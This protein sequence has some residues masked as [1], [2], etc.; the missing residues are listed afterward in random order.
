MIKLPSENISFW[1]ASYPES[2]YPKLTDGIEVDVVVVGAGITGLTTAYLLK[3]AG[4]TVVVLDKATIGGGTTGRTT[5]K[6]TSQHNL[7][8]TDL[9]KRLGT[10]KAKLYGQANQVAVE[11]VE[12]II[13]QEKIDCDWQSQDNFVFTTDPAKVGDYKVEAGTAA[14]L[15]LSATFE[16]DI[17][18]PF[19]VKGA[20]KF[21]GQAKMN[22]QKYLIGLAR[23]VD[24]G[25]S[26]VFEN[27]NVTRI[28]GG[29]N[30][31]VKANGATVRSKH[32]VV[33][34]NV[35]TLPLLAR[36][37]YCL[38]EYP[39]ESYIVVG[40][41]DKKY[42]GMYIS[43]DKNNYSVLPM[44]QGDKK[45]ILIGG[46]GHFSGM[47]VNRKKRY[48]KLAQYAQDHFG[49]TEIINKW[50]DRDYLAYD[51]VPLVGPL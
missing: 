50:S 14:R 38:F 15:G 51:N 41:P 34:T 48:Q 40:V 3:Q 4:Y 33:A 46:E 45:V 16:T 10:Q 8:Y 42:S 31:R 29:S 25:G 35:P 39:V 19:G 30:C 11:L 9:Q 28:I 7:I 21:S 26:H 24:G 5:G 6:V 1:Q 27:S 44:I 17:P 47:H 2:V 49:V 12:K 18:L 37:A 23:K 36:G 20:V 43:S 32:I 13:R 22:A